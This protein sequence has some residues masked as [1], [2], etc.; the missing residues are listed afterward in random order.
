MN[1]YLRINILRKIVK[2]GRYTRT[3]IINYDECFPVI[4]SLIDEKIIKQI[5]DQKS[6]LVLY[7]E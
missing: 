3:D 5:V 6:G 1:L 7:W 2:N 4:K